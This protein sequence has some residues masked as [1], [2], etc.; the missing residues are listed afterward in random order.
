V[1]RE[2]I[3]AKAVPAG[4]FQRE[5]NSGSISIVSGFRMGEREVT[6]AEWNKVMPFVRGTEGDDF[7]ANKVSWYEAVVFCNKL[8]ILEEKTPVYAV[9]NNTDPEKWGNIPDLSDGSSWYVSSRW[10][11]NGYRLPT[12]M[13][14]HWA[15][16]GADSQLLGKTNTAGYNYAF[17]G[18]TP[19]ALLDESAWYVDNSG[20]K[21]HEAAGK[22]PNELGLYDMSGNVMEWCWD[23]VSGNYQKGYSLPGRQN[24]YR[25]GD[26]NTGNKM[27]RGGSYLSGETALYLNYRGNDTGAQESPY[28][29]GDPRSNDGYAGLR[30]VYRD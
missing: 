4:A 1:I 7:P 28:A 23:W 8:S 14:W 25:G 6:Q 26:N 21:I 2:L 29:V 17:A 9:N 18:Y 15:A 30:I 3:P 5:N 10:D 20:G 12:E 27:R 19:D 13:E 24:N 22:K 11:A 16:M